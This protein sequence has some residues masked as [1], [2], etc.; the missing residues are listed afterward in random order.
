MFK[1]ALAILP[2]HVPAKYHQA[3][4]QY[5]SG[6]LHAAVKLFSEIIDQMGDDRLVFEKRGKVYQ[7][8]LMDEKAIY[9]FDQSIRIQSNYPLVY[10]YR[11]LSKVRIGQLDPAIVDFKM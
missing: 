10:Y 2:H 1:K 3:L 7:E 11:G 9:D 8:L 5:E 6:D 4:M